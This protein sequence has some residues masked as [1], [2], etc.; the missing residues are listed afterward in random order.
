MAINLDYQT[1]LNIKVAGR[2]TDAKTKGLQLLLKPSGAKYWLLRFA[3][4]GKRQELGLGSFPE[5]L[6][7]QA[8]EKAHD[9]RALIYKGINPIDAK[10]QLNR[11]KSIKKVSFREFALD[12]IE[13]KKVEWSNNKHMNQWVKTLETYAYPIIGNK[14]LDEIDTDDILKILNPIW[15]DKTETASRLRGR[16]EWILA[17]ATTRKLR[18][19]MNPALWRGHLQTILSAPGKIMEV[20]HHKALPYRAIP[21]F[22]TKLR[23]I[24][25]V[26]ALALEFTILNA[27]RTS[28]VTGGLRSKVTDGI[29]TIPANRMKARK[30]HRVPL[31]DRSIEILSISKAMDEDSPYLFS[32]A[33]KPLSNMAMPM[34]LRRM[35]VDVTVH[36]FRSTFRDWVSEETMHSPEVAEMALAHTIRNKVEAAYRRSD[37]LERRRLLMNDWAKYCFENNASNIHELRVA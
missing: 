18:T 6:P 10:N 24:D 14:S 4:N 29:W 33:G 21:S 16:L 31:C 36:G 26:S 23:D 34:M 25:N 37:L 28:E 3:F 15:V 8:R 17:A 2:Y 35:K 12:C 27:S 20:E 32:R 1:V 5:V 7:K 30:E 11:A 19:G 9:A 22:M 13:A